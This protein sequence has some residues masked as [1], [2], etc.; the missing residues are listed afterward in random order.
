MFIEEVKRNPEKLSVFLEQ[1]IRE[2]L[3]NKRFVAIKG[4]K[5]IIVVGDVHGDLD[6]LVKAIEIARKEGYPD[7]ALLVFLGDYIDRGPKQIE[8]ILLVLRLQQVYP[9]STILLRG[10]HEPPPLLPPY[11]HDF[12]FV[13]QRLYGAYASVLYIRFLSVF[14]GLPLATVDYDNRFLFLHGGVPV[15]NYEKEEIKNLEEYLG[16]ES[17]NWRPEYTE[18][19]WNDPSD[20]VDL[21]EPSPRG[22]GFVWGEKI[23][24]YIKEKY[25]VEKI[26]RGHEPASTGYKFNHGGRVVTLFSR[27]GPPY[28]NEKACVT[29]IDVTRARKEEKFECWP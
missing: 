2:A 5:K 11:P 9:E 13:L 27:L 12:P 17:Q 22:A 16:G 15:K 20:Y 25:G 19:L 18:I 4:F 26:F 21:Y 23:T 7:K 3:P 6:S 8:C 1:V 14:D 24:R 29:V 28:Y 10:N